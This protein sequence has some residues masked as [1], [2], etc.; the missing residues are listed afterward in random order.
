MRRALGSGTKPEC[1]LES[2]VSP[3]TLP[4]RIG[5]HLMVLP[6]AQRA[7]RRGSHTHRK[8]R[9][10]CAT[11][12]GRMSVSADCRERSRNVPCNQRF[13]K[14][15]SY[16]ALVRTFMVLLCAHE[17]D[18]RGSHTSQNAR[19]MRHPVGEDVRLSRLLGTKP[20]CALESMVSRITLPSRI[21]GR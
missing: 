11:R 20:E 12:S 6:C 3:I 17:A 10:V 19:C 18:R 4:S 8:M 2:M 14:S 9:D 13:D 15:R 1:D 7:D 5:P 21:G 16:R